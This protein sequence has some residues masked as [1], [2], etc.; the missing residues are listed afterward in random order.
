MTTC[1]LLVDLGWKFM[2]RSHCQELV[3]TI[4]FGPDWLHNSKQLIRSQV[5]KPAP[6]WL[7]K[8]EQPIRSQV[9]KLAPDCLHKRKQ[10]IRSQDSKLTQFLTMTTTHKFP[11][12]GTDL[13]LLTDYASCT[14]HAPYNI[15]G[16][17][18][19]LFPLPPPLESEVLDVG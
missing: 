2:S 9:S 6:D 15:S 12:Q 4:K 16:T 18:G 8:S 1:L 3:S 14:L 5:S 17:G 7:N 10:L 11:P 13:M 19:D